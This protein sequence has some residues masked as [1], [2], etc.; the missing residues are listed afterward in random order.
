MKQKSRYSE[1]SRRILRRLKKLE[2]RTV[3]PVFACDKTG[4]RLKLQEIAVPDWPILRLRKPLK[5][6]RVLSPQG[7]SLP[8]AI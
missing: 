5:L 3:N 1:M 4:G 2:V 6:S 8:P 7:F